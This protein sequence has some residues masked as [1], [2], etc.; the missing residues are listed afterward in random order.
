MGKKKTLLREAAECTSMVAPSGP[1]V[2]RVTYKD[3]RVLA[4]GQTAF[5]AFQDAYPLLK[6]DPTVMQIEIE[7]LRLLTKEE[8]AR[9]S[10]EV[11][12]S[13]CGGTGVIRSK[14]R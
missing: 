3:Q 6:G 1:A 14:V 4:V 2:W 12:C 13:C 8:I 9:A 7:F 11:S 5:Y 10:K